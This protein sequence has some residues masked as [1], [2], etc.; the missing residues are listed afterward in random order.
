MISIEGYIL[1]QQKLSSQHNGYTLVEILVTVAIVGVITAIALPAY[2]DSTLRAARAEGKSALLEVSADQERFY[3]ANNTYSTNA[4]PLANPPQ[5]V[6]ASRDGHYQ[7]AVAACADGT[8]ANCFVA[9]ATPQG[10]Q[11]D[12]ECTTLTLSNTGVRGATGATADE[13]WQR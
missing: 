10:G 9:T 6:R 11:T 4:Q 12:D 5:A 7:I 1:T 8:I 2:Q 13:C 3:S